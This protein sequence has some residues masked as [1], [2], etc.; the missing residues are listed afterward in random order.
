MLRLYIA[1]GMAGITLT[2]CA[3]Y[4]PEPL[5]LAGH[6]RLW[7]T[8]DV[9]S[10]EVSE[11]ARVLQTQ[12]P[13]AAEFAPADGISL[14]E[15]EIVSL[16]Y[17][18]GLRVARAELGV[19]QADAEYAGLLPDPQLNL[20]LL[21]VFDSSVEPWIAAA[22]AAFTFPLLG[23]LRI[24][25]ARAGAIAE[26]RLWRV[27]A[28][29]MSLVH[30]V[31]LLWVEWSANLAKAELTQDLIVKIDEILSLVDALSQ[32]NEIRRTE[33][34]LFSIERNSLDID[35]HHFTHEAEE[36]KTQIV[37]MMGLRPEA[38]LALQPGLNALTASGGETFDEREARLR[39]H[40]PLLAAFRSDHEAAE[41]KL[42]LEMRN[43]WPS[44]QSGP[45]FE[46]DEGRNKAGGFLGFPL[47]LWNRN[48]RA[49]AHA[50]AS[51]NAA[52][53]AY[54]SEFERLTG[55]LV[56]AEHRLEAAQ[57]DFR[58]LSENLAPLVDQQILEART[59]AELGD[60]DPLLLLE[61]LQ[62]GR[63]TKLKM[64]DA[65]VEVLKATADLQSLS[66]PNPFLA[67]KEITTHDEN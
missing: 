41:Q 34:R 42:R 18:R 56:L 54:E 62:R 24:E 26:S 51:R 25:K 44:V 11:F 64:I 5:D 53:V 8:R 20:S 47:P 58:L 63:E 65:Q 29:E 67:A 37:L 36:S 3:I 43:V 22:D 59:L 12:K 46:R 32:A 1:L 9:E 16:F 55:E 38:E 45:S 21:H 33:A 30:D 28:Q 7:L 31:R 61:A 2:S 57:T 27:A 13:E 52:R 14:Q 35:L 50:N 10:H 19:A 66:P 49:I 60:F 48:Q 39:D 40:H 15:A 23:N 4:K 17:N 6:H